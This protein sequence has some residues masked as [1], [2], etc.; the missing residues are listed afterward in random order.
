MIFSP[1]RRR[2]SSAY[3]G[4]SSPWSWM[5]ES[6]QTSASSATSCSGRLTNTPVISSS[7]LRSEPICCATSSCTARGLGAWKIMP[8]AHAP[9]EAASSASSGRVIPQIFTC[10]RSMLVR[11]L[12]ERD[13]AAALIRLRRLVVIRRRPRTQLDLFGLQ[14]VVAVELHRYRLAGPVVA[15]RRGDVCRLGD[16]LAVH[17]DD[18][19]AAQDDPLVGVDLPG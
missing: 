13:R 12:G 14:L 8:I 15:D 5:I 4:P 16:L 17:L 7:R 11:S 9:S 18:D 6:E 1:V 3:A 19:V 10:T 2:S